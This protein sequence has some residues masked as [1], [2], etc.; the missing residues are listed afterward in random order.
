MGS[1]KVLVLSHGEVVEYESPQTL[2][3]DPNSKFSELLKEIKKKKR[4]EENYN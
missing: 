2:M 3:N 1:D 4:E